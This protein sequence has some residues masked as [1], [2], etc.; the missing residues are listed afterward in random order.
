MML[1]SSSTAPGRRTIVPS[2]VVDIDAERIHVHLCE[3]GH[4]QDLNKEPER[5]NQADHFAVQH[6]VAEKRSDVA[7]S[8]GARAARETVSLP[9]GILRRRN[10]RSM[11]VSNTPGAMAM[12]RTPNR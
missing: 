11:G 4:R 10:P 1:G 3:S 5:P 2:T 12:T 7:Y 8:S 6:L 9:R